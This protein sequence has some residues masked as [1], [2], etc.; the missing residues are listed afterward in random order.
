ML[1]PE[2]EPARLQAQE[3]TAPPRE[4]CP[5]LRLP[6]LCMCFSFACASHC[7]S[8]WIMIMI[9]S[10]ASIH[11]I[12]IRLQYYLEGQRI[13]FTWSRLSYSC[14]FRSANGPFHG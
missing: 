11:V 1:P 13:R 14:F 12:A 2:C 6:P 7:I 5:A 9:H 4:D 3:L 8:F 10:P